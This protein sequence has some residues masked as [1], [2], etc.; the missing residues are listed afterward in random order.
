MLGKMYTAIALIVALAAPPTV[1][2]MLVT[3]MV[4]DLAQKIGIHL[5]PAAPDSGETLQPG[6]FHYAGSFKLGYN[7]GTSNLW[8]SGSRGVI[9]ARS[10]SGDGTTLLITGLYGSGHDATIY[11][12][13]VPALNTLTNNMATT[14]T[15]VLKRTYENIFNDRVP[16]DLLSPSVCINYGVLTTQ[17]SSTCSNTGTSDGQTGSCIYLSTVAGMGPATYNTQQFSIGTFTGHLDFEKTSDGSTWT[18]ATIKNLADNSDV[19]S[20]TAGGA[21]QINYIA[22]M[23]N[24]R[25]KATTLTTGTPQVYNYGAGTW[26][27][28]LNYVGNQFGNGHELLVTYQ[29]PYAVSGHEPSL[30]SVVL[31]TDEGSAGGDATSTTYGPWCSS[32]QGSDFFPTA[33]RNMAVMPVPAGLGTLYPGIAGKLMFTGNGI[34]DSGADHV[35]YGPNLIAHAKPALGTHDT[36]SAD[37]ALAVCTMQ[38]PKPLVDYTLHD[39]FPRL[40]AQL[41]TGVSCQGCGCSLIG[42]GFVPVCGSID[43][44]YERSVCGPPYRLAYSGYWG[45][46]TPHTDEYNTAGV[47]RINSSV[48]IEL[49]S[50]KSVVLFAALVADTIPGYPYPDPLGLGSPKGEFW[51]GQPYTCSGSFGNVYGSTGGGTTTMV[52]RL[53]GFSE[54]SLVSVADGTNDPWEIIDDWNAPKTDLGYDFTG[55]NIHFPFSSSSSGLDDYPDIATQFWTFHLAYEPDSQLMFTARPDVDYTSPSHGVAIIDVFHVTDSV[56]PEPQEVNRKPPTA[57]HLNPATHA[58]APKPST[59]PISALLGSLVLVFGIPRRRLLA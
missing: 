27:M 39:P 5:I 40:D 13:K 35:A 21:Y 55:T 2:N 18:A 3:P 52:H 46:I 50:G 49:P 14:A 56:E 54:A 6:N 25:V 11:E 30:V 34:G 44:T 58:P 45:G 43:P 42:G 17:F 51:Y 8:L 24:F 22:G 9:A 31:N 48:A 36:P 47:D 19:T 10:D 15:A 4:V 20:A 26:T 32:S 57:T 37:S 38:T 53:Y 59:W 16:C 7:T 41:Y 28:G 33:L 1:Q 23:T 29:T 12:Y